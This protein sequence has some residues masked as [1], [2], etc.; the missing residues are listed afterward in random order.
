MRAFCQLRAEPWRGSGEIGRNNVN[1]RNPG[2]GSG[3]VKDLAAALT[4]RRKLQQLLAVPLYRNA[5]YLMAGNLLSGVVGL[6]FWFVAAK[7]HDADTVGLASACVSA[8]L[9]LSTLATLG[10]D[11]AIIRFLPG[12]ADGRAMI[13][14]T[15]TV[16]GLASL[17]ISL[18]F[19]AGLDLWSPVLLFLR[20]NP[21]L[22]VGF[23]AFT[24]AYTLYLIQFRTFVARR[25][26]EFSLGQN[27]VFNVFRLGLLVA[28]AFS[29]GT[30][31]IVSAWGVAILLALAAGFF[32]FQGRL[33]AGY[34]PVPT[35]AGKVLRDLIR[36]SLTNYAAVILWM[37]PGYALPLIV[38]NLVGTDA[39]AY[40]YI[41]WSMAN[42]LF[43][44]PMSVSFSLFAEGSSD[45]RALGQNVRRSLKLTF[46]IITPGILVFVFLGRRLLG[47]FEPGYS[48]NAADLLRILALSAIPL[49]INYLY[50]VV[51]RVRMRMTG[52][53]VLNA[54][55][56]AGTLGVSWV[57]LPHIGLEGAGIAWISSQ[58]VAALAVVL[59]FFVRRQRRGKHQGMEMAP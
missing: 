41:A 8:M 29:F 59:L 11:Y 9:L 37:A 39:N 23:V 32:V 50:F 47:F 54:L 16:G 51:E 3:P 55:A 13:N 43:Q 34:R 45:E 18:V 10:L 26:A 40:F 21:W 36:Y 30:F 57:L 28:L 48:E 35:I 44:V 56:T 15:L 2:S 22:F 19:M 25:R 6:A 14:T 12:S 33:E 46:L 58:S 5:I 31:G 38:A 7:L 49:T 52:V 24:V 53:I 42:V 1:P 17:G 27:V 4:S 20:G